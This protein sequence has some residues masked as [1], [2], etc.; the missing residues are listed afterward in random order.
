MWGISCNLYPAF[1]FCNFFLEKKIIE[2]FFFDFFY[3]YFYILLGTFFVFEIDDLKPSF[4]NIF[5]V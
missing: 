5:F 4:E 3:I 2:V 1:F